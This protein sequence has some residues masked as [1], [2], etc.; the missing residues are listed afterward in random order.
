MRG[1]IERNALRPQDSDGMEPSRRA[2]SEVEK[3]HYSLSIQPERCSTYH[4]HE[5][6]TTLA[7]LVKKVK[8]KR[9]LD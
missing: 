6:I 7:Y 3:W 5:Q 2:K 8:E 1:T 9:K 4:K